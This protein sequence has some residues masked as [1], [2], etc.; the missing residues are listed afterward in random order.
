MTRSLFAVVR[1]S[2][3]KEVESNGSCERVAA[4][5]RKEQR[6]GKARKHCW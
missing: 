4:E 3:L 1:W 5:Y 2:Y 6:P